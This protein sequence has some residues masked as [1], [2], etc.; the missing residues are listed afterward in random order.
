MIS[1][2]NEVTCRSV[3]TDD[4]LLH[5]PY[6]LNVLNLLNFIVLT[7]FIKH[8]LACVCSVNVYYLRFTA[9]DSLFA[10]FIMCL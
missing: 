8:I 2:T 4:F 1:D 10:V 5:L 6:L 7:V 9:T 3:S